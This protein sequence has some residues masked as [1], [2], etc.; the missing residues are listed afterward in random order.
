MSFVSGLWPTGDDWP[1]Q[2][3]ESVCN[4][5]KRKLSEPTFEGQ[6]PELREQAFAQGRELEDDYN[7]DIDDGV[8]VAGS[9]SAGQHAGPGM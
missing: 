1:I 6:E 2:V 3:D 8:V 4:L 9:G 5:M 7:N